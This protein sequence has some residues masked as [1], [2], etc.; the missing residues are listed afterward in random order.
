MIT[1]S[2]RDNLTIECLEKIKEKIK[3]LKTMSFEILLQAKG[4]RGLTI[5]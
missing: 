5:Y 4:V 1:L 2:L 3:P